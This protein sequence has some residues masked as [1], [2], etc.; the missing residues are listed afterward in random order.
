MYQ[1]PLQRKANE[2]YGRTAKHPAVGVLRFEEHE[3]I[4]RDT[5]A[6]VKVAAGAS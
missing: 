3:R 4:T 5:G 1:S 2:T 6:R